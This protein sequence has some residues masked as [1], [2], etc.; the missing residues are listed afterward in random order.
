MLRTELGVDVLG[1]SGDASSAI[2][3]IRALHPDVMIVDLV[4]RS[5]NGFEVLQALRQSHPDIVAVVLTNHS[6]P[7]YRDAARSLGVDDDHYFDKTEQIG[8][9]CNLIRSMAQ[10][11]D[12]PS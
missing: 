8:A 11:R 2:A 10:R 3:E 12:S 4:L 9:M 1:S 7:A 6:T 5:G